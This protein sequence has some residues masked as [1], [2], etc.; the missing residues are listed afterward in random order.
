MALGIKNRDTPH[1]IYLRGTIGFRVKVL[2]SPIRGLGGELENFGV[3]GCVLAC[4]GLLQSSTGP[5]IKVL[6][7]WAQL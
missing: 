5:T 7:E 3:W 1:S 6:L 4:P 2:R